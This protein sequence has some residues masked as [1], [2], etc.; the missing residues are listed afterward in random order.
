MKKY[1]HVGTGGHGGSEQAKYSKWHA[2]ELGQLIS[3]QGSL[4]SQRGHPSESKTKPCSQ[5]IR[6]VWAPHGF[7]TETFKLN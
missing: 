2:K 3:W 7:G 5:N 4:H 1:L 6:Q